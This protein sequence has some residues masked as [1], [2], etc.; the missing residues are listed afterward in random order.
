LLDQF[1][2]HDQLIAHGYTHGVKSIGPLAAIDQGETLGEYS[3]IFHGSK[4][5]KKSSENA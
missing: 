3:F 2:Y 4:V 1:T 5:L